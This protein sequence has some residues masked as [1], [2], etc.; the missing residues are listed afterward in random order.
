MFYRTKKTQHKITTDKERPIHNSPTF[1]FK[2]GW[3][4]VKTQKLQ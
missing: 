2:N 1:L 3:R 4:D